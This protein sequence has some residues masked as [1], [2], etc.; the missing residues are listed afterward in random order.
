LAA[1]ADPATIL[2]GDGLRGADLPV[3]DVV[4]TNPP[5]AGRASPEGFDVARRVRTPE[6][7]V[8]F[9]D[10]ALGLLRPG[11]RLGIVLP[12]NKA[13]GESFAALRRWL[14]E[15]ARGLA[16]VGRPRETFLPHTS[17]RTFVLFA[18]KR[19]RAL[20]FAEAPR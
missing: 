6:R 18:Q 11:G 12:Y 19:R 4:A 5:F 9:L 15:R 13:S 10:R 17:Q 7:D 8:L 14:V 3:A 16:V 20:P 2:R 1:S